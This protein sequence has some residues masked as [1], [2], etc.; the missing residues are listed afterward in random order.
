MGD[1][2]TIKGKLM[3]GPGSE[4]VYAAVSNICWNGADIDFCGSSGSIR[5]SIHAVRFK[6]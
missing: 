6:P 4:V 2:E 5:V 3:I 1:L